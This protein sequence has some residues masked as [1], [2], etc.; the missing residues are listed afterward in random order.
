MKRIY[1]IAVL[2]LLII[3]AS[4]PVSAKEIKTCLRTD[5]NLQV[6]DKFNLGSNKEDI[7]STPC[8]DDMD[9]IYDFAD[10]LT[11][12]EEENLF[13]LVNN[14]ITNTSYDLAIVLINENPKADEVSYA[15]DFY[16]YNLFGKNETRDGSLILID[17]DNRRIYISTTGYAIKMYDDKRIDYILDSG[18]DNLKNEEYYEC[19]SKMVQEMQDEFDLGYPDSNKNMEIDSN[20]DPIYIKYVPYKVIVLISSIITLIVSLILYFKTRL[21]IKVGSTVSYLKN[22][23]ITLKE[24]KFIT[25]STTRTRI[26]SDISSSGS[27]H[28]GGSSFHS[29]SSGS[30]H[31]GGGRSF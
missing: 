22:A 7:L 3:I 20:G 25:A 10:L 24:D 17:M 5:T 13:N 9:K 16:D 30:S 27:S 18:F 19:L 21:K 31:G 11:N 15:D 23:N 1:I 29:S 4:L 14:Y 2:I 26:V 8:V 28:G 6:R 12:E